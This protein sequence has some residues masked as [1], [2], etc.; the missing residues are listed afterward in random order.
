[1]RTL[2]R[3]VLLVFVLA[4]A[5]A[6]VMYEQPLWVADQQLHFAMWRDGARSHVVTLPQGRIRYFEMVAKGDENRAGGEGVPLLLIHGLSG[7]GEDFAA[8][9][10]KMAAQGFHVYAPDLLGYGES[11][12][13]ESSDYSVATEERV[14]MDFMDAVHAPRAY[15]AGWSMG[16]WITLK[17]AL[18]APQRV[19]RIAVYDSAGITYQTDISA[20]L[21]APTDSAGVA[22]LIHAMSPMMEVPPPF[23][24]RAIIRRLDKMRWVTERSMASMLSGRDLLDFK[25]AGMKPPLLIVFGEQDVLIPPSVG[26]TM[27]QTD[28]RSMFATVEGC[29]HFLPVECS[30]ATAKVSGEFFKAQPAMMGGESRLAR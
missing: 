2:K 11:D 28:P 19:E 25:L 14:V 16:G 29:G 9:M 30:R 20:A 6:A 18:D 24:Q 22:K 23:V 3:I 5:G 4:V 10:P 27:H 17:L 8:L 13:P 21:F 1:M 26:A 12:K 7:R 15:I